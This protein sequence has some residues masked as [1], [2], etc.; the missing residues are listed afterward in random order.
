[1]KKMEQNNKYQVFEV[2]CDSKELMNEVICLYNNTY[3]TNFDLIDYIL[4]EVSF[5]K[6][7][8]NIRTSDIFN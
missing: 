7:G 1:M 5:A 2:I 4:D 6:I 3:N 8:G